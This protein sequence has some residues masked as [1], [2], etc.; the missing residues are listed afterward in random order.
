MDRVPE[1]R[2]RAAADHRLGHVSRRTVPL[3]EARWHWPRGQVA[4]TTFRGRRCVAFTDDSNLL[5]LPRGVAMTN[6]TLE[7]DLAV[8]D[9]RSFHGL[10]WRVKGKTYESFFLRPHQVG[11][12]DAVQYTPVFNDVSAWQLYHGPGYWAPVDFPIGRWF[13]LRVSF[14]GARGEAYVGDMDRPALVFGG[15]KVPVAEGGVGLSVGG[16]GLRVAR[17]VYD[18]ATPALRG[19]TPRSPRRHPGTIDGW[20]VSAPFREGG[21]VAV[22]G[23]WQY[24]ESEPSGLANLARLHPI[25]RGRNT[26][27]ARVVVR[28]ASA[29]PRAIRLGFSDR[30]T[31]YLNGVPLYRGDYTYR[32]RDYRFLGSIGWFDTLHLPLRAGDNELSVAVS[33]SFGGWGVQARFEDAGG[34]T[35]G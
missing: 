22:A 5:A 3:E 29:G 20:W 10:A 12:P 32:N 7:A 16:P 4:A 33:E 28:A 31:V 6:G 15:L 30:A 9:Q 25:A 18:D 19:P 34:L 13:R 27:V 24:L 1:R 14:A 35:F 21:D 8:T 23:G 2:R 11:N 26:V 17:F